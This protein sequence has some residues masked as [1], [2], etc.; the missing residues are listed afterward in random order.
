MLRYAEATQDV[1]IM[2]M[3][4]CGGIGEERFPYKTPAMTP[5]Q[6]RS[7]HLIINANHILRNLFGVFRVKK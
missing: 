4:T 2:R 3:G 7:K 1:M 5:C 6:S